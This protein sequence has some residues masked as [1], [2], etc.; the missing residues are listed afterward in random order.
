MMKF[1]FEAGTSGVGSNCTTNCPST[2]LVV[3]HLVSRSGKKQIAEK[4][5][6]A[7]CNNVWNILKPT[8]ALEQ[9]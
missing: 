7:P 8:K 1:G 5:K 2:C 4:F 3:K 6:Q 9:Y